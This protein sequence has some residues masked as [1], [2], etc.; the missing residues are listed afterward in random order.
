MESPKEPN[1]AVRRLLHINQPAAI[2]RL[3]ERYCLTKKFAVDSF[4][5]GPVGFHHA[6]TRPYHMIILGYPTVGMDFVRILKGLVRAG[7]RAPVLI[8]SENRGRSKEEFGRFS[9]VIGCIS[10]PLDIAELS[11]YL[12]TAQKPTELDPQEKERLLAILRKWE[13]ESR[14]A[15]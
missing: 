5:S 13:V 11:K 7:I 2:L 10:K 8:I 9:N 3:V 6:L 15:G 14:N 4:E 12:E 1:K